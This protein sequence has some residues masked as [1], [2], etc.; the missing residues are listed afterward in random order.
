[1]TIVST[2]FNKKKKTVFLHYIYVNNY[3][4][5]KVNFQKL[6]INIQLALLVLYV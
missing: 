2:R 3:A 6:E 1:M 5:N 4:V